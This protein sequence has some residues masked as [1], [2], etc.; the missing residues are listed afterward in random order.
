MYKKGDLIRVRVYGR[1]IVTRR[2]MEAREQM[3][4]VTT[5]EEYKAAEK[6]QREPI[7]IGFPLSD[8]VEG[9]LDS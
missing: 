8:V 2:V 1:K 6:E 5:D 4:L 3:V 7:C 9:N